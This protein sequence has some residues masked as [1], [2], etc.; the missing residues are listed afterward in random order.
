MWWWS[1][2]RQLERQPGK[3]RLNTK[4]CSSEQPLMGAILG[5]KN[6]F[7]LKT[8]RPC[9]SENEKFLILLR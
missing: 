1:V 8:L 3:D 5:S 4:G 2:I 7:I 6:K 9:L